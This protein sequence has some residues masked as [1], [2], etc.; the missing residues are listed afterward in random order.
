LNW[1]VAFGLAL[2][3][4]GVGLLERGADWFA[5]SATLLARRSGVP[6]AIVGLL[7]VG[8]EWEELAVVAV[9]LAEGAPRLASGALIGSAI[10]NM[11]LV[12][13]AGLLRRPIAPQRLDR[14]LGWIVLGAA[15][16][17]ASMA[18][19]GRFG[20][21]EGVVLQ[22]MFGV[23]ALW[24]GRELRAGLHTGG[25][26][27]DD[28]DAPGAARMWRLPLGLAFAVGG[29]E[30]AV[31]GALR[32]SAGAGLSETVVGLTLVAIGA[33]LPD[34]VVSFVAARRGA[35][36][37]VL[38]NAA[39][40]NVCN[41]LLLLGLVALFRPLSVASTVLDVDVPVLLT[42]TALFVLA[43][44]RPVIGRGYGVALLLVYGLYLFARLV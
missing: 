40:S 20:Q 10:A 36:A 39:G 23:Y 22:L 7:T 3:A 30:L 13:S 29:G 26:L 8:I 14:T 19:A 25:D 24:L 28:T 21:R 32:G 6:L 18:G 12:L 37:L 5:D 15:V 38:A 9:A 43:L 2:L 11:T 4:L 17:V 34:M 33:S 16:L 44:R 31:H 27:D 35:G 42:V 1:G 41:L